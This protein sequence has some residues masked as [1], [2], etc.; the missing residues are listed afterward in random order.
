MK[1]VKIHRK[2]ASSWAAAI[3]ISNLSIVSDY[4]CH[5][6][7]VTTQKN[8]FFVSEFVLGSKVHSAS[9]WTLEFFFLADGKAP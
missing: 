9:T 2:S 5:C 1:G 4:H 6:V 3:F 8:S 7:L